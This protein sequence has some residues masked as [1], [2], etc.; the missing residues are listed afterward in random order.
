MHV[1]RLGEVKINVKCVKKKWL[2]IEA[3]NILPV[4]SKSVAFLI[5]D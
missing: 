4:G 3:V 2:K 1:V 5:K